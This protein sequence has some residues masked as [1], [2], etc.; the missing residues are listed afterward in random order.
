MK[1]QQ[2]AIGNSANQAGSDLFGCGSI[3]L[4]IYLAVGLGCGAESSAK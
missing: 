4:W 2:K 1:N 3:W